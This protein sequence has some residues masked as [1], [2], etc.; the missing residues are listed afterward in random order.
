MK[1]SL[2]GMLVFFIAFTTPVALGQ[3]TNSGVNLTQFRSV[4][5]QPLKSTMLKISKSPEGEKT[6]STKISGKWVKGICKFHGTGYPYRLSA[7]INFDGNLDVWVTGYTNSQGRSRC[8]D[9]WL[10]NPKNKKYK[11][12]A[13]ASKI[14]NL[15]VA[16]IEKKLEG[17][18]SNCGCAGQCFF[19]DTYI[20]KS[21]VLLKVAR[22]EQDCDSDTVHY[23]EFVLTDGK[24][25]LVRQV[26]GVADDKEYALRQNGELHFLNWDVQ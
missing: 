17:G 3:Q 22:R 6:Y 2:F 11:Y 18:V 12:S 4:N 14:N 25:K 16:S 13:T 26:E 15:E 7:D 24:L 10:Y 5:S 23:K 21:N 1:L 20:W 8:S 9:V 19:H